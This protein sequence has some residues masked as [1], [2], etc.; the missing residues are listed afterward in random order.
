MLLSKETTA[1]IERDKNVM[2]SC[3]EYYQQL[4]CANRYQLSAHVMTQHY[5]TGM[6]YGKMNSH[7]SRYYAVLCIEIVNI[8]A[9]LLHDARDTGTGTSVYL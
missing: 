6:S 3:N 7:D 5:S 8:A 1:I 9:L 2:T 4:K